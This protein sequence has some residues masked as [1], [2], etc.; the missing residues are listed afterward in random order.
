LF[1]LEFLLFHFVDGLLL[2]FLDFL[3]K[4]PLT[5]VLV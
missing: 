1:P 4:F 3:G 5:V 2:L